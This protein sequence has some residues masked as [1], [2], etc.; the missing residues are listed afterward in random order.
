[1]RWWL[2]FADEDTGRHL[3]CCIAEGQCLAGA[4][5]ASHDHGCNPGGEVLGIPMPEGED[6]DAEVLRHGVHRLIHPS[7]FPLPG[8]ETVNTHAY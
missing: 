5:A 7:A 8:Y 6:T 4:I 3:G 2:S 1:M